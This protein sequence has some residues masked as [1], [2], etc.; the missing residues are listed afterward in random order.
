MI[1]HLSNKNGIALIMDYDEYRDHTLND[2]LRFGQNEN[3]A[4]KEFLAH[5]IIE[6]D[7]YDAV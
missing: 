7:L 4:I 1:D 5:N 3:G 6:G 2:Q